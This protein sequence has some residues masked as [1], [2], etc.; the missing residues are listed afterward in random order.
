MHLHDYAAIGDVKA[1][2][3][4]LGKSRDIDAPNIEGSTALLV[5]V[6][7]G[8]LDAARYLLAHGAR[9]DAANRYRVTPL[10]VATLHGDT[11]LMAALLAAR[12]DPNG[13]APSE[14]GAIGSPLR[15]AT[16]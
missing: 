13:A 10:Y 16:T 7:Q 4:Q 6:M 11:D 1:L 12:A 8:R 3:Q 9:A 2:Q 15:G 5:A 14:C